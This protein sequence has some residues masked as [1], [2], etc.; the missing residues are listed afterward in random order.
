MN[1][2][3]FDSTANMVDSFDREEEARATLAEII[4]REPNTAEDYVIATIN[5]SGHIVA[6][7]SGASVVDAEQYA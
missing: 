1:Y 2:V 6:T 4:E 7:I 5:D 3:I